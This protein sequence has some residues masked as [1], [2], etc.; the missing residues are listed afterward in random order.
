M[1]R[2]LLLIAIL[3]IPTILRAEAVKITDIT[4]KLP[5]FNQ[6]MAYDVVDN[7]FN[8]LST[9][10]VVS[11]KALTLEA[12]YAGLFST[13]NPENTGNKL[14]GVL[15]V[16]LLDLSGVVNFPIL[17][18]VVF[19]PGIWFGAGNIGKTDIDSS[20]TSW[21]VSATVLSLKF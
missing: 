7:Q 2:M 12:G 13:S 4:S 18:K 14:V 3:L 6:G 20:E 5:A 10:D 15:S 17:D 8:Y 9:I 16:K 11:W 19:R 21:G 1:K